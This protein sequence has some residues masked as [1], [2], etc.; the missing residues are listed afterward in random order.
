[1][2]FFQKI[3]ETAVNAKCKLACAAAGA[4]MLALPSMSLAAL[5]TEEMAMI[6]TI[7]TKLTDLVGAVST[8]ATA[9]LGLIGAMVVAALIIMYMKSAGR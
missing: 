1:M 3:K 5:S 6:T 9:N 7:T 8:I 4:G 2:K